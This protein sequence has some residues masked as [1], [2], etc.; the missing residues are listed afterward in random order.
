M[1]S[2]NPLQREIIARIMRE[3]EI[4][5]ARCGWGSGKTSALVFALLMVSKWRKGRSSLLITDTTPRYNSVLMPEISKWLEPMGW[6]YNHTLRQWT[7]THTGSTVW[8]RSYFRPNTREATH[9][10]LEGLNVTS[11]VCLVD[12]CQTLNAEVAHKA[13]GR[14]RAGPTPIMILVG[15]PVVDA[16]WCNMAERA[17]YNP[18]LYTSYV[19]KAN[20][21]EQWFESTKLLPQAEREAM[22][23]NKPAPPSG[24]IYNE[25]TSAHVIE[26][27]QYNESMTGRIAIDWGFRKPSVLIMAYDESRGATVICHEIN[28]AEVTTSQLANMILEVAWPRSLRAQATGPKIWLDDGVA[29]KAGRARND[30]TGASAFRAM[31]RPPNQGGIGLVLRNTTDPIR[32]DILNGVQR[33]KRAFDSKKYLITS[34]LWQRG[35]RA[36]GNSLRKALLSYSWDNKEQPKKDGRE[37]PLDA[38]RYDCIMFNW[39]ELQVDRREYTSRKRGRGSGTNRRKV[40]IGSNSDRTF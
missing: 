39:H 27:W 17:G 4:I 13:L 36:R 26:G 33:L 15:L 25:F 14:L 20:L 21:S 1:I 18:L 22:V 34:E 16:W 10:P 2:L 5:S 35:E 29:D 24:L 28:P 8:C 3:D 30:Q 37:D 38:L 19:N 23:M 11:G 31:R 7:D 12:E 9:N 32:V 40:R 6:T